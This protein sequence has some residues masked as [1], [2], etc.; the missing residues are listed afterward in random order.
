MG[1]L[2]QVLGN[3]LQGQGNQWFISCMACKLKFMRVSKMYTIGN[4]QLSKGV[5]SYAPIEAFFVFDH[6][7][8]ISG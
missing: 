2:T 6:I 8:E 3:C 4:Y 5:G 7:K 1:K